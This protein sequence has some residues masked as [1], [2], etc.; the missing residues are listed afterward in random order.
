MDNLSNN[1][2]SSESLAAIIV[3][4]RILGLC[5]EEAKYCMCELL[6]RREDENDP[7]LFEE[8]IE[9]KIKE[10]QNTNDEAVNNNGFVR[11]LSTI[12]SIG[13]YERL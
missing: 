5:K 11:F 10:I 12:S 3:T 7:F 2:N 13:K 6:R 1:K 9:N 4:N 8:Y